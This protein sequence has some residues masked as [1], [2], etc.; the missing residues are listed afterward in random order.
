M[1]PARKLL[2]S[3][4]LGELLE[5]AAPLGCLDIGARRGPTPDLLPLA[6]ACEIACFE[7][8]AGE[9]DEL[10]R[11]FAND[12]TWRSIRFLPEALSEKGGTRC[13]HLTR[14]RG[15]STML[16]PILEVGQR[17]SREDYVLVDEVI[18]VPT[19][20]LDDAAT[21]YQLEDTSYLKIDVEGLELEILR[22][23]T[24]LLGA[25]VQAIRCEVNFLP[26]RRLQP[27]YAEIHAFLHGFGFRPMGFCELHEWR[28]RHRGRGRDRTGWLSFSRGQ[29]AH[30]DMLFLRAP[31]TIE[32]EPEPRA[33]KLVH[34]ALLALNYDFADHAQAL[35]HLPEA[36][37]MLDGVSPETLDAELEIAARTLGRR[38]R[39]KARAR[40]LRSVGRWATGRDR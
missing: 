26:V 39:T 14:A 15:C 11:R 8:D 5:R 19:S 9:C 3:R 30:G 36:E 4:L 20:T 22:S 6:A 10:N 13:L 33:R 31:E 21:R 23:G 16:E 37:P 38:A 40:R 35:L 29:I 24:S 1:Q 25:S 7:P 17:F 28:R 27:S 2:G 34:N 12:T 18:E 32:G